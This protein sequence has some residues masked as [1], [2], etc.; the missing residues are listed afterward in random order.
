MV[1]YG[2]VGWPPNSVENMYKVLLGTCATKPKP[3]FLS[4][5]GTGGN[6]SDVLIYRSLEGGETHRGIVSCRACVHACV[7]ACMRVRMSGL[8]RNGKNDM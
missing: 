8:V 3:N 2:C 1:G 7:H 6:Y 5:C 4:D